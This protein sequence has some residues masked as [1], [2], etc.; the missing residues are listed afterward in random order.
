MTTR[1]AAPDVLTDTTLTGKTGTVPLGGLTL[2]EGLSRKHAGMQFVVKA[3]E[4][5]KCQVRLGDEELVL[6]NVV[7]RMLLAVQP[8]G[9]INTPRG[10]A[11]TSGTSSPSAKTDPTG[12]AMRGVRSAKENERRAR[13]A[14][15]ESGLR[16]EKEQMK[17]QLAELGSQLDELRR[18]QAAASPTP[19]PAAPPVETGS[20]EKVLNEKGFDTIVK[21]LV[22]ARYNLSVLKEATLADVAEV[23]GT[24]PPPMARL[25]TA[26][27]LI[28][29]DPALETSGKAAPQPA[30]DVTETVNTGDKAASAPRLDRGLIEEMGSRI[31]D[32]DGDSV[33]S[34]TPPAKQRFPFVNALTD[35][36]DETEV[37]A[38]M[39][40]ALS[41]LSSLEPLSAYAVESDCGVDEMRPFLERA[42]GAARDILGLGT[43]PPKELH[44][45][46]SI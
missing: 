42:L 23:V 13:T 12:L 16:R 34:H 32:D 19:R 44:A 1:H 28:K 14:E 18:L 10:R 46:G 11:R 37:R 43:A 2:Y 31:V 22:K 4:A 38:A 41:K 24:I 17:A 26:S 29:S 27:G 6:N 9:V 3:E 8:D 35:K 21:P 36:C 15:L 20:L 30:E 40:W 25:L 7:V 45:P 39:S 33:K 5:G